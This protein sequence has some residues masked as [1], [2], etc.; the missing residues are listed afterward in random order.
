[1]IKLIKSIKLLNQ[2][3]RSTLFARN[4]AGKPSRITHLMLNA[5]LQKIIV[6][7]L[8]TALLASINVFFR[9]LAEICFRT[10]MK[11]K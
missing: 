7:D 3:S 1:M 4:E 2:M 6:F 9:F 11:L 5:L 8:Q 10:I